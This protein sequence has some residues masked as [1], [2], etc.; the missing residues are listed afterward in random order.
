MSSFQAATALTDGK[1]LRNDVVLPDRV[2]ATRSMHGKSLCSLT[3]NEALIEGD[4]LVLAGG[5]WFGGKKWRALTDITKILL[6]V[7]NSPTLLPE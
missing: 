7:T 2:S 3:P 4:L 6:E 1:E 5:F